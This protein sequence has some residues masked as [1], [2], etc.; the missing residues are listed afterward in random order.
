[1]D[2]RGLCA[3]APG[4][5]SVAPPVLLLAHFHSAVVTD[6]TQYSQVVRG[7]LE[8]EFLNF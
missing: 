1:M 2:A 7:D 8:F 4:A 3:L 6:G 5:H